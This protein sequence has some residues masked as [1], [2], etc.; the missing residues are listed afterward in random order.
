MEKI[1]IYRALYFIPIALLIIGGLFLYAVY[2]WVFELMPAA[3]YAILGALIFF[4]IV[5]ALFNRHLLSQLRAKQK[6][7]RRVTFPL[8]TLAILC[9]IAMSFMGFINILTFS[10]I[11]YNTGPV[12]TWN[13]Y[14]DPRSEI[15]V[16]WRTQSPSES[17]VYYGTSPTELDKNITGTSDL[18]W[19]VVALTG[20]L[21]NT[22]Y[23]YRVSSQSSIFSF[24]TAP[25]TEENFTFLVFSD[26]RQNDGQFT[27]NFRPNIAEHMASSMQKQGISPAFTI[28]CGDITGESINTVT[29]K[30]WFDD[31][32]SSGL[33]SNAPV[34]V[35][36]GNHE[37]HGNFDG[38]IF[39]EYYPYTYHPY[40]Y[41]SYNYSSVH[42]TVLDSW[43][44]TTGWWGNMDAAQ[45]AWFEQDLNRS[46]DMTYKIVAL[47]TDIIQLDGTVNPTWQ[48]IVDLCDKYEVDAVFFGHEHKFRTYKIDTMPTN[49]Y[50]VGVAGNME[51][52]QSGF[53]QVDVSSA[54]MKVGMQ[55]DNGTY[56]LL[57]T[58]LPN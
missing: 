56:Q 28:A 30:S 27:Y 50:L 39:S 38:K 58:I 31:L 19:H 9:L 43:N 12:L 22:T 1:R 36:I 2:H 46:Q 44:E 15:T 42:V 53:A 37:R 33:G 18:E 23:H 51:H 57:S 54:S 20:L 4:S 40:Y 21:A 32:S 25:I 10:S 8:H 17:I 52:Y 29:W 34:Q 7:R 11:H 6:P 24:K 26:P 3:G 5:F 41:Y 14:Q 35:A 16:M 13:T 55:W 47:H 45:L 49:Y 48:P